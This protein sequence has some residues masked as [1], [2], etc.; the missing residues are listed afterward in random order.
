[1]RGSLRKWLLGL[2]VGLLVAGAVTGIGLLAD[3]EGRTGPGSLYILPV[4][5]ATFLGG[6]VPGLV[7]AVLSFLGIA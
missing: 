6:L 3:L 5:I 2:A 1:M 7:M 4:A